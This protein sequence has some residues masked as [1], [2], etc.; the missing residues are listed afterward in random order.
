M[1]PAR[2]RQVGLLRMPPVV[3]LDSAQQSARLSRGLPN[4]SQ[5]PGHR[6]LAIGSG[7][8]GQF[9]PTAGIAGQGLAEPS[10]ARADVVNDALGNCGGRNG[11]RNQQRLG[12]LFQGRVDIIHSVVTRAT[13]GGK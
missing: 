8:P 12:T 1:P 9:E 10:V 7:D 5:Q 6:G 2:R 13:Y 4:G 3:V 11:V